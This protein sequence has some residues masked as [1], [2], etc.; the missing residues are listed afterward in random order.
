MKF[1][2]IIGL[3]IL[4]ASIAIT[5]CD[6]AGKDAKEKVYDVKGKVVSVDTEKKKV[7]LDHEEIPGHMKAMTMPFDVE[8]AKMLDGLKAGDEVHGKLRVKDGASVLT[9]VTKK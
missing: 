2:T 7:T 6:K 3:A 8:N 4:A 5:G 9:E 1:A